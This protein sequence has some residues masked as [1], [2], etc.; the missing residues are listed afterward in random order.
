MLIP[1]LPDCDGVGGTIKHAVFRKILSNQ[2]VI[3]TPKEFAT[4]AD[5]LLKSINVV[6]VGELASGMEEECRRKARPVPGTL[7]VHHIVRSFND[8]SCILTFR[9]TSVDGS[10]IKKIEYADESSALTTSSS[11][12]IGEKETPSSSNSCE[13][14]NIDQFVIVNWE[15]EL[16]P[17]KVVG[18][19]D[20]SNLTVKCL[21][22]AGKPGS[23]WKWPDKEDVHDYEL[24]DVTGAIGMPKLMPGTGRRIEFE[25]P[26][27]AYKWGVKV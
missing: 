21:V 16:Y 27:L 22:P 19:P 1:D 23:I 8:N 12:V 2:V 7:K 18:K 15:G 17:G 13:T 9:D 20:S 26:E 24:S 6:Y 10:L 4:Y 25:V 5:S 14:Y 11:T 3:N